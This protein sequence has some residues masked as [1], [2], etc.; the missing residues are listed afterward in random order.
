MILTPEEAVA[1]GIIKVLDPS[2]QLQQAGIDLTLKS[3]H[4]FEGAGTVDFDNSKRIKAPTKEIPWDDEGKLTLGP[5]AYKIVLNEVVKLPKNVIGVFFPRTTLLRS[6]AH[7]VSGLWDPGFE[8]IGEMLL[9]VQ[10]PHGI[11]LYRNA[12]IGQIMFIEEEKEFKPYQGIYKTI[13]L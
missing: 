2:K 9:I 1:K 11:I 5:G 4:I 7:V 3:V 10:N 8:G 13:N 6:G 12:R